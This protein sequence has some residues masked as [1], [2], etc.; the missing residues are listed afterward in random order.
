MEMHLEGPLGCFLITIL[1]VDPLSWLT[2]PRGVNRTVF[3]VTTKLELDEMAAMSSLLR[4][5]FLRQA[6]ELVIW[7][8][9]LVV[10]ALAT[11][12]FELM[13]EL[14]VALQP[15]PKS[16]LFLT[17]SSQPASEMVRALTSSRFFCCRLTW[18]PVIV[19]TPRITMTL[20][21]SGSVKPFCG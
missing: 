7:V 14:I 6:V 2:V 16:A 18:M 11:T 10:V 9:G 19:R 15:A 4:G 1:I 17:C 20:R 3:G 5:V 21:S 12:A 8:F 13:D